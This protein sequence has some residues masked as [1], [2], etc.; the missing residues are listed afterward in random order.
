MRGQDRLLD[1]TNKLEND[2][3]WIKFL[4]ST[5]RR[6]KNKKDKN[7]SKSTYAP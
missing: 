6:K 5:Y 7:E 1:P 2:N 3:V 4:T